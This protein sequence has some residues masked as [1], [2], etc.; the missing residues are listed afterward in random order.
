MTQSIYRFLKKDFLGENKKLLVIAGNFNQFQKL[1]NYLWEKWQEGE[2][3]EFDGCMLTYY[4][5]ED[6]VR[7]QRFDDYILYGTWYSRKDVDMNRIR[8]FLIKNNG[9]KHYDYES[10]LGNAQQ[11][12]LYS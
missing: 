6:S 8:L 7:G 4:S 2:A 10:H 1:C 5:S 12:Y 3:K 11:R 9:E